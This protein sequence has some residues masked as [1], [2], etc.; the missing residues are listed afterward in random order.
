VTVLFC[1]FS[2]S[3]VLAERI[4]P[5]AMHHLLD[6]FFELALTEVD[7]YG[8]T[9]NQFLGDGFMALFGAPLAREDN[10][11]RAVLAALGLRCALRERAPGATHR[12]LDLDVRMGLNSGLVVVGRIGHNLR[13]DYTAVGSTTPVAHRLEP[14]GEPGTILITEAT[15]RL[16]D[17]Y[18]L[19]TDLGEQPMNGKADPVYVYEVL[20]PGARRSRLKGLDRTRRLTPLVGREREIGTLR[21]LLERAEGGE[22]QVVA[23]SGE[24]GIGKSPLFDEFRQLQRG[25]P[26][27]FLEGRCL[28]YGQ[29]IPY[30]PVLDILRQG[31]GIKE[32]DSPEAIQAKVEWALGDI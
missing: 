25:R 4:G 31:R 27:T 18:V 13:M 28:S 6:E 23:V 22:G 9:I 11:R 7:R 26:V 14:M 3:L 17:G 24:S 20:G 5:E 16:V 12:H 21:C 8:G 32:T 10:A 29:S 30:L 2:S 19:V 1:D 15:H